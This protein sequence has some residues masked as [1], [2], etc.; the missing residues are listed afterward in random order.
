MCRATGGLVFGEALLFGMR[1]DRII[2][3]EV[4]GKETFQ[5]LTA[6]GT[7]HRGA[8][9]TLHA[10]GSAEVFERLVFAMLPAASGLLP[11]DLL[12]FIGQTVH[13]VVHLRRETSG[14][15]RWAEIAEV[16]PGRAGRPS[17]RLLYR[18][19]AKG[20]FEA[21]EDPSPRAAEA[22]LS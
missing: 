7:G 18:S 4:R 19:T 16:V 3:G 11:S 9:T 14:Q 22:W 17:L 8:L 21:C 1:P 13:L 10:D 12:R 6:M 2:V 15:R 5:L 20:A